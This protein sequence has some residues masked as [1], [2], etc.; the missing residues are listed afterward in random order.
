MVRTDEN[1]KKQSISRGRMFLYYIGWVLLAG[2]VFFMIN[3]LLQLVIPWHMV[4]SAG[5]YD[6]DVTGFIY[7]FVSMTLIGWF[8]KW[9]IWRV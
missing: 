7:F 8:L 5:S 4:L 3:P 6:I 1:K 9:W 2:L